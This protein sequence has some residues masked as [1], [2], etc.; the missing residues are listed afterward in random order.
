VTIFDSSDLSFAINSGEVLRL[1]IFVKD[2]QGN[3]LA[4]TSAE[5]PKQNIG[6][7]KGTKLIRDLT[8]VNSI[9]GELKEIRDRFHRVMDLL[10]EIEDGKC[11][12]SLANDK[13]SHASVDLSKVGWVRVQYV[14]QKLVR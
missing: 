4:P 12:G 5:D 7:S 8:T 13:N 14:G 1:C 3:F 2:E 9:R 11:R 10:D 6:E